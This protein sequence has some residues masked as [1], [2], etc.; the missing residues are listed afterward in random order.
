MIMV[1][2]IIK[3][4]SSRLGWVATNRLVS[5]SADANQTECD[6]RKLG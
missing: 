4:A 3:Y 6:F 2:I 1:V 5:R